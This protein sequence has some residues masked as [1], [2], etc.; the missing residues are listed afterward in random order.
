MEYYIS[1]FAD[2]ISNNDYV[3]NVITMGKGICFTIARGEKYDVSF[4]YI[5]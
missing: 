2:N 5:R 3:S 4:L 1:S